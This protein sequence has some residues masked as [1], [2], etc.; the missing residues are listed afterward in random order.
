M[1]RSELAHVVI[2]VPVKGKA[3]LLLYRN[4]KWNDWSLVGG[5]VEPGE[6]GNWAATAARECE[7][8]LAPLKYQEDFILVPLFQ[9]PISWGPVASRS[10]SGAPTVYTA[11]F[12]ALEF[13]KDPE[14]CLARLRADDFALAP[15]A[16]LASYSKQLSGALEIVRRSL[17]GGFADVPLS[18]TGSVDE[19][20]IGIGRPRR[21]TA[22]QQLRT[23]R[24]RSGSR[25]RR[26]AV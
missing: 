16:R 11:Q 5:H 7:E 14:V 18:W 17:R 19:N 1:R 10:A 24:P 13:C 23:A 26:A 8:E 22:K 25:A 4:K 6:E 20:R 21:A 12:F 3:H 9:Q 2:R 15:E